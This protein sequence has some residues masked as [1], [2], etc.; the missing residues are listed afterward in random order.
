ME[1]FV[2]FIFQQIFA[3]QLTLPGFHSCLSFCRR[4]Q[5]QEKRLALSS[6]IYFM[7]VRHVLNRI[8]GCCLKVFSVC[9]ATQV[10][11]K[12]KKRKKGRDLKVHI[13]SSYMADVRHICHLVAVFP[14]IVRCIAFQ[15]LQASCLLLVSL[16]VDFCVYIL[17]QSLP[18]LVEGNGAC[19]FFIL[20]FFGNEQVVMQTLSDS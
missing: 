16:Y 11:F 7:E 9:T 17:C 5:N 13:G 2:L 8:S 4:R 19:L 12:G 18:G 3:N 20:L 14:A 1:L 15:V 10:W 6:H